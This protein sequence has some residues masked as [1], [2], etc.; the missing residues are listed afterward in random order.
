[1]KHDCFFTCVTLWEKVWGNLYRQFRSARYSAR[2][3]VVQM[4]SCAFELPVT[5]DRYVVDVRRELSPVPVSA[6][7]I[8]LIRSP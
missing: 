5:R 6:D 7:W 4:V 3:G 2:D 8:S 1:M